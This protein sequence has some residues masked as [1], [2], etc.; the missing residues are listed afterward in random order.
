MR[1]PVNTDTRMATAGIRRPPV[2][3][4]NQRN[5]VAPA[6]RSLAQTLNDNN[7]ASPANQTARPIISADQ[8]RGAPV[9][10]R[11]QP[12]TGSINASEVVQTIITVSRKTTAITN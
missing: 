1:H 12:T 5:T 6:I 3:S 4:S 9:H 10:S 11:N 7:D 8:P 2:I